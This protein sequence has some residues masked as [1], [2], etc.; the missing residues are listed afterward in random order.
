MY[1]CTRLCSSIYP[2]FHLYTPLLIYLSLIPPVHAS[3]HLYILVSTCTRLC[4]S[5][6]PCFHL[7]TP[8]LIYLSLFSP[9][10]A[11]SHIS[12]LVSICTRLCWSIYPFFH[13]YTP[14]SLFPPG[15]THFYSILYPSDKSW[16]SYSLTFNQD[17]MI[18]TNIL[19][20]FILKSLI[21][22]L[23]IFVSQED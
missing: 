21:I 5:I 14:L 8:L 13:L 12:I 1:T 3:A 23:H 16:S 18:Y 4:S 9:V 11:F 7:Y 19:Y 10:H 15:Q 2:C 20:I 22:Y 6:Y 17:S